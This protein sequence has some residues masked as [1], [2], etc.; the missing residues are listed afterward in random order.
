MSP[1]K[2]NGTKMALSHC[3]P[4]SRYRF[5]DLARRGQNAPR[6]GKILRELVLPLY[7]YL[8]YLYTLSGGMIN[9]E[10]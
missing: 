7:I 10:L 1:C 4:N 9:W 2:V 8:F 5:Q 3:D 6:G